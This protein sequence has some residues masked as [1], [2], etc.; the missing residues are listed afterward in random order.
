MENKFIG[1]GDVLNKLAIKFG[2]EIKD[3]LLINSLNE[4]ELNKTDGLEVVYKVYEQPKYAIPIISA[5]QVLEEISIREELFNKFWEMYNK[6]AGRDICFKKWRKLTEKDIDN[7][8]KTLP[9]YIKA[10][11][12]LKFRKLPATYLNQRVWEDELYTQ[13]VQQQNNFSP[14][15]F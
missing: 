8:F 15:K 11:P 13:P 7:I 14:F 5:H 3:E 9:A 4:I 10:T 2:Y 6:K 1:L 12:D